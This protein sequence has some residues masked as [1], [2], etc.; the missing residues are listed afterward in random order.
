MSCSFS[1][2]A[3]YSEALPGRSWLGYRW[4]RVA[5]YFRVDRRSAETLAGVDSGAVAKHTGDFSRI[6]SRGWKSQRGRLFGLPRPFPH[7]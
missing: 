4:D 6:S 3:R 7:G 2:N 5:D 1:N